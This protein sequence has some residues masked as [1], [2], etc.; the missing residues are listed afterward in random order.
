MNEMK[1]K[2][3]ESASQK[4]VSFCGGRKV[5][6]NQ[7]W[8]QIFNEAQSMAEREPQMMTFLREVVLEQKCLAGSIS[9]RL[10]RKLAHEDM[11]R[12]ELIPLLIGI[13][14]DQPG[15]VM[16]MAKDLLAINERDPACY[17]P[18]QPLLFFKG[19]LAISTY[20]I[21]HH[22]WLQG[23]RDLAM[24]FQSLSSEVFAVDIHPAARIGW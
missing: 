17:S 24:Y 5:D 22:L 9:A 13:L 6:L 20:R 14:N 23:R 4:A 1:H 19:F 18:L 8:L 16:S 3:E 7:L 11:S 10:A 12:Q 2:S 21:S 15:L